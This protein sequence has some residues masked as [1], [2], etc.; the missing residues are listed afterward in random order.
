MRITTWLMPPNG[1]KSRESVSHFQPWLA[2]YARYI[3]SRSAAKRFASS[4]PSAP[5][6]STITFLPS[7]ASRGNRSILS[8]AS[9]D[10]SSASAL[11]NS[12]RKRS[13]SSPTVCS[14]SSRAASALPWVSRMVRMHCTMGVICL[15]KRDASRSLFWSPTMSGSP[16]LASSSA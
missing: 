2:A 12:S 15:Y 5:R 14:M 6:I 13:R 8:S 7:F 10:K 4:P 9:S 1:E 16:R 3:S 11:A